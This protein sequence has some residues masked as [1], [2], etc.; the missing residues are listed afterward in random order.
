MNSRTRMIKTFE[1]DH[2]D[3]IPVL[4]H[5]SQAGL[6]VHGE[7]LLKLFQEF[8]VDNPIEFNEIPHPDPATVKNGIYHETRTDEWGTEWEYLI[9]GI[10]GQVK[11]HPLA[12]Y[13]ALK[14]YKF[15][16]IP[17]SDSPEGMQLKKQ[18]ALQ[19][20]NYLAFGGSLSLF[21]RL[22]ALRPMEDILMDIYTQEEPFLLLLDRLTEYM[23]QQAEYQ[24]STGIDVCMVADDWG[25][26]QMSAI[27]P[28]HFRKIFRPRY[29]ELFEIIHRADV[30]IFFHSCGC[31]G[32]IFDEL[33]DMG[34]DGIW[35]QAN[36]YNMEEF[37]Q[38]CRDHKITALLHPDRQHL[39]PFGT[40]DEI[41]TKI[42]QY[43]DVYHR[44]GGG[45]IFYIEIENDAPWENAE[46]LIR[47]VHEFR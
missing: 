10:S 8:P 19:K 23:K 28:E 45:G 14:T 20:Q 6:H 33:A 13:D 5:P 17:A 22:T 4:Y 34:I 9:Y 24:V 46:A 37:A 12:D 11:K 1:Y 47:A 35:H 38:K 27:S 15:P 30:K 7:K 43:A 21:E 25:F 3:K 18:V 42:K 44:L 31:L 26:Q 41:R 36:R 40:P 29:E 39:I 2:P 32:P 16:S